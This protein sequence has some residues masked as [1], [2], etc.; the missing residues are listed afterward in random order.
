MRLDGMNE[1]RTGVYV[2]FELVMQNHG[3]APRMKS[4]GGMLTT[5]IPKPGREGWAAVDAGWMIMSGHS[6]VSPAAA[7]MPMPD[8]EAGHVRPKGD[9]AFARVPVSVCNSVALE[10]T[11]TL[12]S[13]RM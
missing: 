6:A 10:L 5:V 1:V 3:I 12:R 11:F 4:R 9:Q 8:R 13:K 2:F 7:R